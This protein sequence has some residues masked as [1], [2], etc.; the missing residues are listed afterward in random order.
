MKILKFGPQNHE[1]NCGPNFSVPLK[2]TVLYCGLESIFHSFG[3]RSRAQ[4][5]WPGFWG[6]ARISPQNA[7][8][9]VPASVQRDEHQPVLLPEVDS[10]LA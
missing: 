9:K 8:R 5:L 2:L 10:P 7:R 3:R 1:A 6:K 4:G